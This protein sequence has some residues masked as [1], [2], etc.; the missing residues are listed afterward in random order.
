MDCEKFDQH[1]IDALYDELDELTHAALKRHVEGCSRC[2][3]IFTGLRATR[4]VGILPIEEPSDDLEAR[5]ST[6]PPS[7]RSKT[8]WPRKVLRG[9][10]W[11]G[12]HAMRPQLAMAALFFLVIGS[13]LLLL[14]AKPGT[15]G[16]A[17]CA[18]PSAA[19]APVE[20]DAPRRRR[21]GLRATA[22]RRPPPMP[23]RRAMARA[24]ARR[25]T[26]RAPRKDQA[27]EPRKGGDKAPT[28]LGARRRAHGAR[29]RGCAAAVSKYDEIGRASRARGAAADAMW[30]AASCYDSMGDRGQSARALPRARVGAA[31][32]PA[33]RARGRGRS[34]EQ[35]PRSNSAMN[36]SR[37]A[38]R[39]P[40]Q[41][42]RRRRA[43][44]RARRA[45]RR[46]RDRASS[47]G[48]REARERI[49][50]ARV[51]TRSRRRRRRRT[52]NQV[53]VLID[54]R[55]LPIEAKLRCDGLR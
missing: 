35:Q 31:L 53:D 25:A 36:Q 54:R 12:S 47:E 26:A 39:R 29:Q 34:R 37:C 23:P 50:A 41:D 15:G 52:P 9:L 38:P 20:A 27:A 6:P 18:S 11:A 46:H 4:D 5:S 14:R 44:A 30:E 7:R 21:D 45:A 33:S 42:A 1:V 2:A 8:P 16:F 51:A 17:R 28:R 19:P 49:A 13:S 40:R 55:A 24:A 48:R 43:D 10:A 3:A 22:P 32:P